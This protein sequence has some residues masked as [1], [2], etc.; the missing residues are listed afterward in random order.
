[1]S[2]AIYA[3]FFTRHWIGDYRWWLVVMVVAVFAR[4]CVHFSVSRKER[5]M[6]LVLSFVLIG[7]FVWVAENIATF[8]GAWVYP[9]Q[10][11]VW[12]I[13]SAGKISS[14]SLLVIVTFILVADLK[15]VREGEQTVTR[16]SRL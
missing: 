13:V 16:A 10:Q 2:A 4:T 12:S 7:F 5:S 15:R 9:N 8:F 3:N 11:H 1:M 6:P 14:W